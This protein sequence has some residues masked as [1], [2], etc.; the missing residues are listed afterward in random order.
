MGQLVIYYTLHFHL[1]YDIPDLPQNNIQ[2][3]AI[4]T[5]NIISVFS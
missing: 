3:I 2:L 4:L 5:N 1:V